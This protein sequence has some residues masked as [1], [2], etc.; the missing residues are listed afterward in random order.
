M[1]VVSTDVIHLL[2][3]ATEALLV[4]EDL[5]VDENEVEQLSGLIWHG[6]IEGLE[7]L[8]KVSWTFLETLA[9]NILS[10]KSL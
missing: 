9:Y 5:R 8:E 3:V 4:F 2:N 1:P 7:L 10:L 6:A